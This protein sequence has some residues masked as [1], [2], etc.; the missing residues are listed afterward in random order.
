MGKS[1][2]SEE[3]SSFSLNSAQL[4]D[5]YNIESCSSDKVKWLVLTS[6]FQIWSNNVTL[7]INI[8][9]W[10]VYFFEIKYIPK[11]NNILT[12]PEPISNGNK[13]Q[14][15]GSSQEKEIFFFYSSLQPLKTMVWER[16]TQEDTFFHPAIPKHWGSLQSCWD[17]S[18]AAGS[19]SGQKVKVWGCPAMVL[20]W[21]KC[22]N[23]VKRSMCG[24]RP[25]QAFYV[26]TFPYGG[27]SAMD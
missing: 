16:E 24:S 3:N 5:F 22:L 18:L 2:C 1:K 4:F 10:W 8:K 26:C 14:N 7:Q 23:T 12:S 6:L 20:W 19:F 11:S 25:G 17:P 15:I 27:C 9:S 13:W 21:H